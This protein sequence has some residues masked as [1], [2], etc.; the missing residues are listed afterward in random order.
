MFS[1]FRDSLPKP[2]Q[3]LAACTELITKFRPEEK[4]AEEEYPTEGQEHIFTFYDQLTEEEQGQLDTDFDSIRVEET[5]AAFTYAQ[6]KN[7]LGAQGIS[8]DAPFIM[9]WDLKKPPVPRKG[10]NLTVLADV[11]DWKRQAWRDLGLELY[12]KGKTAI[13][14]LSGGLDTRL[15]KGV[16]KG[17][18]DIGCCRTSRFSSSFVSAFAGCSTWYKGSSSV[19]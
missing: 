8:L 19:L 13:V 14:I 5:A 12:H 4:N 11:P 7:N 10:A 6:E 1:S 3:G 2:L 18:L 9:N 15:G 16:P 17:V